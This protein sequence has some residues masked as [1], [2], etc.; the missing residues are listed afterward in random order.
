[1]EVLCMDGGLHPW[2]PWL[3]G[4]TTRRFT[5]GGPQG[6]VRKAMGPRPVTN[7]AAG[8]I[9]PDWAARALRI[10]PLVGSVLLSLPGLGGMLA[11]SS[12]AAFPPP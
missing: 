9:R 6:A 3:S 7:L 8:R 2:L 10:W 5:R 4:T 12:H 1:M 11:A